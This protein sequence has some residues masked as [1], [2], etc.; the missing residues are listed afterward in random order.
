MGIRTR[1][2]DQTGILDEA[3]SGFLLTLFLFDVSD[4]IR[5]DA[6]GHY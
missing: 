2:Y 1:V 5:L 3:I 4:E 6:F